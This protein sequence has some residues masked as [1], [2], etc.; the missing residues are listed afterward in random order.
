MGHQAPI[1]PAIKT[2][3]LQ[4]VRVRRTAREGVEK[5]RKAG[6]E[7]IARM[8]GAPT[9]RPDPGGAVATPNPRSWPPGPN[10]GTVMVGLPLTAPLG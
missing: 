9:I 2:Q 3:A 4:V 1:F 8:P 7:G 6:V 10:L 5:G